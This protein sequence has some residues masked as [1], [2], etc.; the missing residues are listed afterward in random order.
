[1]TIKEILDAKAKEIESR[2]PEMI[3]DHMH[4]GILRWLW[5]GWMPGSFLEAVISNDFK[6]AC[7]CADHINKQS[8]AQYG[9]FFTWY[10]PMDCWGSKEKVAAWHEQGGWNGMLKKGDT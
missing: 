2:L 1:M 7:L 6:H 9:E 4:D 8:L 3:P 5:D 10:M